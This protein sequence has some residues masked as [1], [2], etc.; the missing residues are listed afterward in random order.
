MRTFFN[1]T[2]IAALIYLLTLPVQAED[3]GIT[4]TTGVL[5]SYLARPGIT[6]YSSPMSVN[7]VQFSRNSWYAGIWASSAF[8]KRNDFDSEIDFYVGRTD[9]FKHITSDLRFSYFVMTPVGDQWI[10][11][12]RISL[13]TPYLQPYFATRFF[14][15]IYKDSPKAGWFNWI[16]VKRVQSL[17]FRLPYQNMV[18]ELHLD[19]T[20]AF[21]AGALGGRA[22]YVYSRLTI[23]SPVN[24]A[25]G[26][27]LIPLFA[28]QLTDGGQNGRKG[29][30]TKG[31]KILGGLLLQ[32]HF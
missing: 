1:V 6:L 5:S 9:K 29:D 11:D 14:G 32:F 28:Y 20:S 21:S 12:N 24:I 18:Q 26:I 17:G 2:A 7:E 25:D 23:T 15:E 13:A 30:Y 4:Y 3:L 8:Q 22:G 16:G 10:F 27:D 19:L 31:D